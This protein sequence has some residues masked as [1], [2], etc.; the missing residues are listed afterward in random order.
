VFG[1]FSWTETN[2]VAKVYKSFLN[3]LLVFDP[4]LPSAGWT[5]VNYTTPKTVPQPRAFHTAVL[6]KNV[7]GSDSMV[8][9]GGITKGS[10]DG[11]R[12][13]IMRECAREDIWEYTFATQA[14]EQLVP[15]TAACSLSSSISF[16][17]LFVLGVVCVLLF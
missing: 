8:I 17:V 6:S 15:H 13:T 4:D 5:R 16:S 7:N 9:F 11:P 2:P 14:W 10:Y 3:D 12:S 1:G